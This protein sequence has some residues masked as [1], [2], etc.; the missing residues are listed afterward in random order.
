[1]RNVK[2]VI[3]IICMMTITGI[4]G[5]ASAQQKEFTVAWSIYAGWNPWQYAKESGI[6][7]KWADNY[8]IEIT[9]LPPMDYIASIE[10]YVAKQVDACVMTNMEALDMPAA[11]G[12]DTTALIVGDYSNGNDAILTKKGVNAS[13]I[14]GRDVFLAEL[15]VSHY[16]LARFLEKNG[17]QERDIRINN[18]TDS[19]IAALSMAE[20]P[21][22][23]VT[24]NPHVLKIAQMPGVDNIYASDQTP[25]EILDLMVVR[26]EVLDDNPDFGKALVGAW[27]EVMKVMSARGQNKDALAVMA[28]IGGSTTIEY[29][30][31]LRTTA[32]FYNPEDATAY[33]EGGEIKK[34]MDYVRR[35]CFDHGLLGENARSAD[36]VGISYP[37]GT[38]QGDPNKIRF[39]FDSSYMRMAAEG[40]L[41]VQ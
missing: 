33:T 6:L 19:E 20:M 21:D 9:L 37:D 16:L 32:M 11:S 26:T 27:Y 39:R 15:S 2:K 40:R 28:E 35:F 3:L 22:V 38:T 13:N 12:I 30:A 34:N 5:T 1:M 29:M 31:M 7:K 18:I 23:V 10:A 17:I 25:G 4:T 41:V 14:K 8:D 24:W 36:V